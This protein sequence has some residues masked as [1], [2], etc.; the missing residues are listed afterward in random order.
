MPDSDHAE[1]ESA[2]NGPGQPDLEG[3]VEQGKLE[4][5]RQLVAEAEALARAHFEVEPGITLMAIPT[6][7]VPKVRAPLAG[8]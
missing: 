7:L 2:Q 4:S 6:E 5:R 3:I 1:R 8:E